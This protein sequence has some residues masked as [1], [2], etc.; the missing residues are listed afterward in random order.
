MTSIQEI[1]KFVEDLPELSETDYLVGG[2]NGTSNIQG[3]ILTDRTRW[4]YTFLNNVYNIYLQQIKP[5]LGIGE[6]YN[7]SWNLVLSGFANG[8]SKFNYVSDIDLETH[9]ERLNMNGYDVLYLYSDSPNVGP[10]NPV[11]YSMRSG[12]CLFQD[13]DFSMGVNGVLEYDTNDDITTLLT[14]KKNVDAS[15]GT[16]RVIYFEHSTDLPIATQKSQGW[17]GFQQRFRLEYD[18]K[19]AHTFRANLP[20][21]YKFVID[22][23]YT[24][25]VSRYWL[26]NNRGTGRV[27]EYSYIIFRSGDFPC[28]GEYT[29]PE[30]GMVYIED[31]KEITAADP[32]YW[33][34]SSSS[35]Y[36]ISNMSGYDYIVSRLGFRPVNKAGDT[37]LGHLE[38]HTEPSEPHHAIQYGYLQYFEGVR[39]RERE[40]CLERVTNIR[41]KID[42]LRN[43]ISGL[44]TQRTRIENRLRELNAEITC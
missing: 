38:L 37:M 44:G 16:S 33:F 5:N 23:I 19:Y 7:S 39:Q 28:G 26:T 25:D 15:N 34:L 9:T 21:G 32:L 18:K 13:E 4:L 8:S 20:P 29:C 3:K 40:E 10:V 27:E 24:P 31:G 43:M 35:V 30:A 14:R 2:E 41:N 6:K 22:N 1:S 12:K 17:G 42:E 36:E 11:Y